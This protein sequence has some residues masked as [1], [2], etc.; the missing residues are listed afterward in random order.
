MYNQR[1]N[2]ARFLPFTYLFMA[3]IQNVRGRVENID[4][5]D[6]LL[7]PSHKKIKKVN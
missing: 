4:K 3:D 6:Q 7:Q 1:T 5:T 2:N